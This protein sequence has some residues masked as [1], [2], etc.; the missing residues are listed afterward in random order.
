MR[1]TELAVGRDAAVVC[2]HRFDIPRRIDRQA[3]DHPVLR[4]RASEGDGLRIINEP[5]IAA[6]VYAFVK[7]ASGERNVLIYDMGGG[8]FN[9]FLLAIEDE[10]F[11]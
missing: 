10:V 5:T 6:I 3:F 7:K 9:V 2:R 1:T 8:T 11:E 4:T